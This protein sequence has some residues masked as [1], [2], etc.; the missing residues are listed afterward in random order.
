MA[1]RHL[2]EVVENAR[3]AVVEAHTLREEHRGVAMG[4]KGEDALM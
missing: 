2:V 1:L 4:V 3:V